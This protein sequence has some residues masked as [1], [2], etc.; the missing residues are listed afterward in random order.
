M[1]NMNETN[2]DEISFIV[3]ISEYIKVTV[4]LHKSANDLK[5]VV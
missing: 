3:E 1:K 5:K 4:I 2:A